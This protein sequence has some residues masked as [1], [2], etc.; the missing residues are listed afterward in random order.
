MAIAAV[1]LCIDTAILRAAASCLLFA[2]G[3]LIAYD[4]AA[5][6]FLEYDKKR[7][8]F[9]LAINESEQVIRAIE[10]TYAADDAARNYKLKTTEIMLEDTRR[11]NKNLISDLKR[12]SEENQALKLAATV[13]SNNDNTVNL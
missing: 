7:H 4:D 5:D 3:F 12:V 11:E 8:E 1:S 13:E 9:E 6:A 2:G 10:L